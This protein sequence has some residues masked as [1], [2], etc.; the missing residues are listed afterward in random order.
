MDSTAL[1]GVMRSYATHLSTFITWNKSYSLFPY[2]TFIASQSMLLK[3]VKDIS[4]ERLQEWQWSGFD[5]A[6]C[7]VQDRLATLVPQKAAG[8]KMRLVGPRHVSDERSW[9]ISLNT[10][11]L[12]TSPFPDYL[13]DFASFSIKSWA[14][15]SYAFGRYE[16]EA[17]VLKSPSLRF[18]YILPNKTHE[19]RHFED[20]TIVGMYA[21]P[22]DLQ[23]QGLDA[24]FSDHRPERGLLISG[25]RTIESWTPPD[26]AGWIYRDDEMLAMVK[27]KF[28]ELTMEL[29]R[30]ESKGTKR[31]RED[32]AE[33]EDKMQCR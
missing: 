30:A 15:E 7:T 13:I 14:S 6:A 23:P 32:D 19:R 25:R 17:C 2:P 33:D 21:L 11:G 20:S 28:P 3:H 8:S 26:N 27:F 9:I 31:K 10:N 1:Y 24:L 18:Q 16:L 5:V 12:E 22:S 4:S 29:A